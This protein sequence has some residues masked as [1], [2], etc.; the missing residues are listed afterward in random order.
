VLPADAEP[1]RAVINGQL[2]PLGAAEQRVI[3][4]AGP[5]F[6]AAATRAWDESEGD[7]KRLTQILKE[8]SGVKGADLFLPL[9][10]ALTG[11][12]H[13]PELAPLL[14]LVPPEI[15]R[16]RLETHAENTQ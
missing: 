9:R 8:R 6:F 16:R 10:V 1:W 7:F 4:A 13:G 11:C 2:A 12:V 14:K 3:G 15:A 5:G